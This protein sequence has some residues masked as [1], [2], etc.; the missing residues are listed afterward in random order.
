MELKGASAFQ[1]AIRAGRQPCRSIGVCARIRIR[2]FQLLPSPE[3]SITPENPETAALIVQHLLT[4]L[5]CN[6]E[7]LE[8]VAEA[9]YFRPE[10]F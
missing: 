8:R 4:N 2:A 9:D 6:P 7:L 3:P 5:R 10:R 1:R